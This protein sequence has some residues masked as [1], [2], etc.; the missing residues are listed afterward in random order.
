MKIALV[1][2]AN[3][4]L[5]FETSRQLAQKDFKVYMGARNEEKGKA[6]VDILKSEGLEVEF[7]KMDVTKTQSIRDFV[8][9]L[10][11]HN[12]SLDVLINNAGVFLESDGPQDQSTASIFKV[13]PVIILKTIETN[14]MGP[15][16]LIQALVPFM[17][18]K[19]EGRIINLSSGMGALEDMGAN[20][21]GYRMSKTALNALT[22]I[23]ASELAETKITVNSVCPGW[24]KTD[25]G[26]KEAPRSVPEGVETTIWLATTDKCPSGGF[27]RDKQLIP[28]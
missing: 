23:T 18:E 20:W 14:T 24:V 1:T 8:N 7:V 9:H 22:K 28:W 19:G 10:K 21:P 17:L 11:E 3:R 13:D 25:M 2:G 6:A 26:G 27:Y 16:K 4:G 12:E 15:L 5:G